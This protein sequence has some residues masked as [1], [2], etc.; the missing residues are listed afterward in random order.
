MDYVNERG[1]KALVKVAEWLEAGAPHVNIDGRHI[2]DFDMNYTVSKAG[3]N[4]G[5]VCCIAGAVY[6]FEGLAGYDI[7]H[8]AADYMGLSS[9]NAFNLFFPWE[10]L[11]DDYPALGD[12]PEPFSDKA[13]A[14][15]TIYTFLETGEIDWIGSG[16]DVKTSADE[17][18]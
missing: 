17:E 7:C 9:E 1:H 12:N 2:D 14:A 16:L 5:T 8:S 18:E 3:N 13:V 10:E 11:S 4:C 6:Q 15:R